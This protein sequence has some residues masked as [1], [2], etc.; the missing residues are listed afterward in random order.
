MNVSKVLKDRK[1]DLFHLKWVR[2]TF[3]PRL[4]IYE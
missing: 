1:T 2:G 4:Q 3:K